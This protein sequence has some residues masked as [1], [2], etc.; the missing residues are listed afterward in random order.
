M[1]EFNEIAPLDKL[2]FKM[3]NLEC[4]VIDIENGTRINT[5]LITI[6][7][8]SK[9]LNKYEVCSIPDYSLYYYEK[10]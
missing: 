7:Y 5:G 10:M 9:S 3:G 1:I 8:F 4:I 2:R 6:A